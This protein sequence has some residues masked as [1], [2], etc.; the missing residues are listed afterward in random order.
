MNIHAAK[1]EITKFACD[2]LV[3]SIFKNE[4][5]PSGQARGRHD[6]GEGVVDKA[7]GGLLGQ[8]IKERH[9]EG[10][11]GEMFTIHTHG[12]IAP[13][14]V[15]VVGL[16]ERKDFDLES[17]RRAAAKVVRTVRGTGIKTIGTELLGAGV[18]RLS[19]RDLAQ[20]LAEGALLAD[21][22]YHKYRDEH[23]KKQ[24]ERGIT[25]LTVI[26]PRAA[27]VAQAAQGVGRAMPGVQGTIFA[28]DL[29]NEPASICTP[30]HLADHARRIAK[31]S[32]G[33]IRAEIFDRGEA[34]RRGMGAFLSVSQGSVEPP[35]FVHLMYRPKRLLRRPARGTPRNGSDGSVAIVGKGITFDTGGLQIKPGDAMVTM[36]QDMSGCA[37]VLGLFSVL[38][39]S[40]IKKE[41]HGICAI[42]E[43][44]VGAKAYK[45]GD[46][47]RASNGK[48]IE[49]GHTDA[50]GRVTLADALVFASKLKPGMIIDLATLTGAAMV[51]LG[52]EVA[53]VMGNNKEVTKHILAAAAR[54]GE[55]FWELPLVP[56]YKSLIKSPIA[57]VRNAATI[58]YGGAIT[59]GLFLSEFVGEIPWAHLDIAGPAYAERDSVPYIPVGGAGFGVRML[60]EYLKK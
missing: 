41:V 29:I 25:L 16:G 3:V 46:V 11:A 45:P 32:Q 31:E 33:M 40:G 42:T 7:L 17:V 19:P 4:I 14:R 20:A 58:R 8:E 43:N 6:R 1:S 36:K 60:I 38:P 51:A 24:E 30:E 22:E 5:P 28:R 34:K 12:K 44:M 13:K 48:T 9:F 18:H 54:S 57:D 2:L 21:Y 50:E 47:V 10:E 23:R 52:T 27:M 37:A 53:A 59:A 56:E 39:R 49:I 15:A 26:D 55:K 35:Y